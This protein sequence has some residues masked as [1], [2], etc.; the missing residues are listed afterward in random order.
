MRAGAEA[1]DFSLEGT[2]G[3]PEGR[4]RYSL[5]ELGGAPVV[6][7]FYPADN[8]PVCT[9]QLNTYSADIGRFADVGAQ[10]LAISPQSVQ[11]HE[12]FAAD[13]GPF[14]FPLLSDT[15]KDVGRAYGIL[16]P[17]G[18][19]R[20]SIF[21]VDALGVVRWSHRATAGLTF[22]PVDEIVDVVADLRSS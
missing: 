4:R 1:P 14:A 12:R 17:V 7:V 22:R 2:D 21:V 20:R 9:V 6:L 3:T 8:S 15:G 18:F 11:D 10:V 5:G 13:H 19:Y 16:G